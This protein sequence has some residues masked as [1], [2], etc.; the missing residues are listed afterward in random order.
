[1]ESLQTECV[2]DDPLFLSMDWSTIQDNLLG[3]SGL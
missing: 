2:A 1:V 3:I